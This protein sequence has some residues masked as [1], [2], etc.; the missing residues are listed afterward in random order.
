M[1]VVDYYRGKNKV[2]EVDSTQSIQDVYAA[3]TG[4]IGKLVSS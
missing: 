2:I 4:P 1:P 3:V